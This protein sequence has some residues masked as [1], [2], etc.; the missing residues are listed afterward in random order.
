MPFAVPH[1]SASERRQNLGP[2]ALTIALHLLVV[3]AL[4]LHKNAP[5]PRMVEQSLKTIFLPPARESEEAAKAETKQER[6]TVDSASSEPQPTPQPPDEP[7]K[8]AEP[9]PLPIR[10][11]WLTMSRADFAASDISSMTRAK[12]GQSPGPQADSTSA[13]GPGD[14]PG[15]AQLYDA[16]WFRRPSSAELDGYLTA[17][18]P[19]EGW[20][21]IA[22]QTIA[23]NR[24]DNCRTLG[25]FPAGSGY[26]RAVREAAWQFQILPPRINGKPMIGSWVRI[27]ITYG[28]VSEAS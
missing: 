7:P 9:P 4:L 2:L 8:E 25:E 17:S 13:Y 18:M 27:R 21:L 15:G 23:R 12:K 22:C 24:V 19:R 26:G 5:I 10:P 1:R 6:E 11:N 28:D 3:T 14:G 16:D 20:G